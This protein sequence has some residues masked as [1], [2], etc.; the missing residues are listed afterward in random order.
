M[1]E[2]KLV[3]HIWVFA[4][5]IS[6]NQFCLLRISPDIVYDRAWPEEVVCPVRLKACTHDG[7]AVDVLIVVVQPPA[8]WHY[9]K[10]HFLWGCW[11]SAFSQFVRHI[12]FLSE[13]CD[14]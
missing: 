10:A 5:Q 3:E 8:K 12:G 14:T 7:R 13:V 2:P 11:T 4:A 6:K 1:R 9:H